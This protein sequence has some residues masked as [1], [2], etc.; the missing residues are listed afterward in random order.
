MIGT[1]VF[2]GMI[3]ATAVSL[4]AVPMLYYLV[5]KTA[6]GA[7]GKKDEGSPPATPAPEN[8]HDTE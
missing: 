4:A 5:Q 1:A 7:W 6:E 2:Y 3:V 8:I